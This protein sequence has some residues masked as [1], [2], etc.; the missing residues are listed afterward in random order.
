MK[1]LFIDLET[2]G[3]DSETCKITEISA[4]LREDGKVVGQLNLV[5]NSEKQMYAKFTAFLEDHIDKFNKKD[6]AFFTGWNS[7]FD[8]DFIRE[9]FKKFDDKFFGSYF[10]NPYY[11]VMQVA[12]DKLKTKRHEIENFKLSTVAKYLKIPVDDSKLHGAKYDNDLCR[13]IY[14]KIKS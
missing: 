12:L 1:L 6:K 11:D 3:L 2:T 13:K 5:G 14:N 10:W 7:G 4:T 9:L 8:M